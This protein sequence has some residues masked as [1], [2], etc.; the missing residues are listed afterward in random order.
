ML[1]VALS[2]PYQVVQ[3]H[4][5]P[6]LPVLLGALLRPL[7]GGYL[8]RVGNLEIAEVQPIVI[9]LGER[10]LGIHFDESV[11]PDFAVA[12]FRE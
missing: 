12:P 11:F 3:M 7:L 6:H 2:L 8:V 5:L 1:L 4:A 9:F 10:A